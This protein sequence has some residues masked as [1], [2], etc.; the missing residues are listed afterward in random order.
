MELFGVGVATLE[1]V[2]GGSAVA[3]RVEGAVRC[4]HPELRG[5]VVTQVLL[6]LAAG[7]RRGS[8]LGVIH[9][10]IEAIA[11]N[12]GMQVGGGTTRVDDWV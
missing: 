3:D 1:V 4:L 7:T 6:D 10:E 9:G 11:A 5:P 12:D 8:R 2:D